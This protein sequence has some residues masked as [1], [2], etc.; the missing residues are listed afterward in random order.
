MDNLTDDVVRVEPWPSEQPLYYFSI[1]CSMGLW[2]LLAI[3]L[4]GLAYAALFGLVLFVTHMTLIAHVRGN[5]VRLGPD[6]LPELHEM[7]E[8]LSRR[9]GLERAPEA[10][11]QQSGGTLNAF[12][13]RFLSADII[14]LYSDMMDACGS[15]QAACEMIVGHELAHVKCRH[16]R[17]AWLLMPSYVIPFLGTALSRAREF[18]CD[19]YGRA[20][21]GSTEGALQG[22]T[23]LAA[24]ATLGPRVN[25]QRLVEQQHAFNF[26]FMRLAEWL[27]THPPLAR[28]LAELDPSLVTQPIE[29]RRG[30]VRALAIVAATLL[31]FFILAIAG[32]VLFM[33]SVQQGIESARAAERVDEIPSYQPPPTDLALEQLTNDFDRFERFMKKEV[34][35]GR[36]LPADVLELYQRWNA[37]RPYEWEPKDPFSDEVRYAYATNGTDYIIWSAGP[38]LKPDSADDVYFDS[39]TGQGTGRR[40]VLRSSLSPR[41]ETSL[42]QP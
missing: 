38:D 13:T 11:V 16:L 1:L 33:R 4:I 35:A 34:A 30:T 23:I 26:G 29:H 9:I 6:Q 3:S 18:T 17:R 41:G 19:R 22:L 21:A 27:S 28:R 10:Y 25:R 20:L 32:T 5:G 12:A 7:V 14:V 8:R 37:A 42:K 15:N 40:P 24:G 39:R 31:P 2:L 36:P